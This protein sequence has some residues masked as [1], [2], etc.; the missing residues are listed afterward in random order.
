MKQIV[1]TIALA[2]L[3]TLPVGGCRVFKKINRQKEH[4]VVDSTVVTN[5]IRDHKNVDSAARS[6]VVKKVEKS[7][8]K[9]VTVRKTT[10]DGKTEPFT[11]TAA[12]KID[13][14]A[15][16]DTIRLVDTEDERSKVEIFYDK[17]TGQGLAKIRNKSQTVKMPFMELS[18]TN[19]SIN[20]NFD[21]SDFEARAILNHSRIDSSVLADVKK[22]NT[23]KTVNREK[24]TTRLPVLMWVVVAVAVITTVA[25]VI[26]RRGSIW[27]WV[28]GV[29]TQFTNK[30]KK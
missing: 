14:T 6:A 7:E 23:I 22:E 16:G 26:I 1:Y 20:K 5:V 24:K 19:A 17:K 4:T 8:L 28:L 25:I 18:I 2:L 21:S 15:G 3:L 11:I 29:I 12:F 30:L 9:N 10:T 13:A 27:G